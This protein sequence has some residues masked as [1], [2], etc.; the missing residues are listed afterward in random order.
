MIILLNLDQKKSLS[1]FFNNVAVAWFVIT[2]I[3]PAIKPEI[4]LLTY[5]VYIV[6]ILSNIYFS[7]YLLRK[8]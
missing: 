4:G 7:L 5:L 8:E 1:T 3:T 6:N 2:F